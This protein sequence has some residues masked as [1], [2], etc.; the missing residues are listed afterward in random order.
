MK[1]SPETDMTVSASYLADFSASYSADIGQLLE[2]FLQ[3]NPGVH[4]EIQDFANSFYSRLANRSEYSVILARL[5][6]EEFEHLKSKQADHLNMLL[7]PG[8]TPQKQYERALQLG[9][10]HEM[11][12]V[13]LPMLMETYHLYHA[14]IEDIFRTAVLSGL[15]LDQLRGALHQRVQLDVEAQIA[16]HARFDGEIASLLASLDEAIQMAG[17]LADMLRNTLEALGD[18]EG[19][20]ACLFSRPDAHG[21]MQI[22][23]EGGKQ[24]ASYAEVLRSQRG[25]M[26]V[27]QATVEAG[28]GPSGRAWRSGQI[29]INNSFQA[30]D[31]LHPWRTRRC[32]WGSDPLPR[33]PLLD[34]S[35]Q[36]FAILSLVQRLAWVFQRR[37]A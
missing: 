3:N 6:P 21:V 35:G 30:G 25:P 10:I 27:T 2:Q 13:S 16:S 24:G 14:K 5:S 20:T 11:V 33:S 17:N 7:S 9:W 32:D 12:G 37:H 36:S 26:F 31:T 19:I 1:E 28:N 8:L 34:E 22:E 23:A 18:F 29:Q 4:D 15:E